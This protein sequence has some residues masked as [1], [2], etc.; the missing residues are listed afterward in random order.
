MIQ[1][2]NKYCKETFIRLNYWYDRMHGL[3]RE[4]IEKANAMVE[5]IEKT[6]SD[7]YP[8][9][10]DSLFFISRYGE[11]SRPF[12]VDAVYGD[13]IVLRNFSCVPFV[14]Q[15]KKGIKCD[16][17]G[18]ECVLVKAGDVRFNTWT[19]DVSSIGGITGH[20]KTGRFTTMRK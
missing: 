14:S 17:H 2:K 19:T 6:R 11:R 1:T 9:T 3:V 18:G 5:H 15:D 4:D 13:N 8:R 16:M 12:F 7:R 10:G 20:V